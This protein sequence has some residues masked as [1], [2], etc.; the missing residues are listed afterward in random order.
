LAPHILIITHEYDAFRTGKYLL[1]ELAGMWRERGARVTI[2]PSPELAPA[3]DLAILHVDLTVVPAE[4]LPQLAHYASTVNAAV[5]DISKRNISANLVGSAEAYDGPV[6]V[7]TDNNALGMMELRLMN[8]KRMEAAKHE[9]RPVGKG[10]APGRMS[11]GSH[12]NYEVFESTAD[13]PPSVW[14]DSRLV[15]ERF[16]PEKRDNLFCLRTWQFFGSAETNSLSFSE[17]PIVKAASVVRTEPA[18]V[19][20]E[21]RLLRDSLR[22]DF[23]KFDYAIVDG[24]VVLYDA[25]RTPTLGHFVR[26]RYVPFFRRLA[27]GVDDYLGSEWFSCAGDSGREFVPAPRPAPPA[28]MPLAHDIATRRTP[29]TCD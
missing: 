8:I 20:N 25:N 14:R 5:V 26:E 9:R 13:V 15:V 2:H 27:A 10:F 4:Y 22:F 12:W 18:D 16:L 11:P 23:G 19:P 17:V 24:R 29:H 21:L 3:A 28:L 7:K 6:I 1:F